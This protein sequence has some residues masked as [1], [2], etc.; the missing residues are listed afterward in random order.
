MRTVLMGSKWHPRDGLNISSH[1]EAQTAKNPTGVIPHNSRRALGMVTFQDLNTHVG[2]FP[3][4][5]CEDK[6]TLLPLFFL[7]RGKARF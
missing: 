2:S 5:S 7:R 3:I 6:G 1:S 4:V